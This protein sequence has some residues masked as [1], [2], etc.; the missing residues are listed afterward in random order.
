[1]SMILDTEGLIWPADIHQYYADHFSF[2]AAFVEWYPQSVVDHVSDHIAA[3]EIEPEA[4]DHAYMAI[5]QM[6]DDFMS[7]NPSWLHAIDRVGKV[8]TLDWQQ[9]RESARGDLQW[10]TLDYQ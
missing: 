7:M 1:M 4:F 2:L 9:Y 10:V 6:F 5:M 8:Y 3:L